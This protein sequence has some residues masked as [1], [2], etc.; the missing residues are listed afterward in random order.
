MAKPRQNPNNAKIKQKLRYKE[1]CKI[2][3]TCLSTEALETQ[4][5]MDIY[6]KYSEKWVFNQV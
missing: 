3:I 1:V 4:K 5:G 2:F 6:L